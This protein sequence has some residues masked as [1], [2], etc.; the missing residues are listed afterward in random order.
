M[1]QVKIVLSGELDYTKIVGQTGPL[2]YPAMHVYTFSA[3]YYMTDHGTNILR[4]QMIF[5]IIY[6]VEQQVIIK[7]YRRAL[8]KNQQENW[9]F[10]V[11]VG[12]ICISK[13]VHSIHM[14]RCFNDCW[15]MFFVWF[16]IFNIQKGNYKRA[17]IDFPLGLG[18]K[19][20][21]LLFLPALLMCYNYSVGPLKTFYV[22]IYIILS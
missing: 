18:T 5:A 3:F 12:L 11:T 1:D 13:R 22:L 14:L 10:L 6:L 4:A 8:P 19:M 17:M 7:I 2:V 20:N 21:V 16:T 9:N 15:A